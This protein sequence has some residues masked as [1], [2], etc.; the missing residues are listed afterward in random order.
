[1]SVNLCHSGQ[2]I[3]FEA[4]GLKVNSEISGALLT[5]VKVGQARGLALATSLP[6][7]PGC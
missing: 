1:M 7:G 4:G 2:T 3:E 5:Q 6:L